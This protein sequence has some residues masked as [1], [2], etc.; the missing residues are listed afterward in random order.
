MIKPMPAMNSTHVAAVTLPLR[1]SMQCF[2]PTTESPIIAA[3]STARVPV[4]SSTDSASDCWKP[5]GGA[6]AVP[7]IGP[8][9][10]NP[11]G[12]RTAIAPCGAGGDG[13]G[14]NVCGGENAGGGAKVCGGV[15]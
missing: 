3:T 4:W 5:I 14:A 11:G 15:N 12:G 10:G 9:P 8:P 1:G 2:T 13:G 7:S 6:I